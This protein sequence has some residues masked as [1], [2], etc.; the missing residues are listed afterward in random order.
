MRVVYERCCG[1]DVHKRSVTACVITPE[2]R[3]TRTFKT[4]TADLLELADWLEAK[5]VSHAAMESTGEY[6][7]PVHNLLEE[8]GIV[9]LVVNARHMNAVPGRKTDVKDAEW[10]AELLQHGLLRASFVPA[11][12]QRELRE[13]T[14][15]RRTLVRQR[16]AMVS[17]IQK[18]LEG[19]NIK[20]SSVASNV[21][22]ASGRAM[23]EGLIAGDEDATQLAS[24]ARGK[25]RDK[26][27]E[28]EK[29]L[30]GVVGPHQQFM[31]R[32][33][34]RQ[35]DFLDQE[36]LETEEEIDR[37]LHPFEDAVQRLDTIPGVGRRVAQE[38]VAAIGTDMGR[39]GSDKRLAS[40]A[41]M[42]PGNF[43][44]AGKR[45][46]GR[47][48]KG[49]PWIRDILIEAAYAAGRT[50]NTYLASQYHQ[51]AARRGKKVA[52]LAVGHSILVIAYHILKNGTTY[53]DLGPNYFDERS[54]H[55]TI[56]RAVQRLQR[57]GYKVSLEELGAAA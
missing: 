56:R 22:G 24:L 41:R 29:A 18:V 16:G 35:V 8:V 37:R 32:A 57:L 15:F 51:L 1:L 27:E 38:V 4:M 20:L 40:W 3:E 31:L 39:F 42:C 13:L 53:Q 50:R 14:R 52:A 17:R 21:L 55:R 44:S 30:H 48:G 34:L 23:L 2:G 28:L 33:L 36:I 49:G 46:S 10:I 47:I 26:Q 5:G 6:W 25:L 54:R 7:K 9:L 45:K 11:R 43:E 19:A 12:P